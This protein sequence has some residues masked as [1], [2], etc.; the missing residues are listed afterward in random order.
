MALLQAY[1]PQSGGGPTPPLGVAWERDRVEE[2]NP[3]S[4][5]YTIALTEEPVDANSI[6]VWSQGSVRDRNSY[7]YMAPDEIEIL[8]SANPA[9]DTAEGV[10]VFTVYYPYAT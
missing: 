4:S 3:F 5:G 8:F 9:T 1:N 2:T 6:I 10:W 7:Q